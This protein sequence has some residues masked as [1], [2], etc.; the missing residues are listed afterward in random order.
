MNQ[1]F[2]FFLEAYQNTP[3][4]QIVLE[5]IAFVMQTIEFP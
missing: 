4:F 2:D 3:T 5:M 1:I